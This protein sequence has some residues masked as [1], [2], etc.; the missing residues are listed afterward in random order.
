MQCLELFLWNWLELTRSIPIVNIS[1]QIYNNQYKIEPIDYFW[2]P[3]GATAYNLVIYFH[4]LN[5]HS[6]TQL[7]AALEQ[8][9]LYHSLMF[10]HSFRYRENKFF[11]SSVMVAR[12]FSSFLVIKWRASFSSLQ[13]D[14]LYSVGSIFPYQNSSKILIPHYPHRSFPGG[15]LPLLGFGYCSSPLPMPSGSG[16]HILCNAFCGL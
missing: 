2:K 13:V 3:M 10:M 15:Q 11:C 14:V 6:G 7:K 4:D 12:S 16:F 5:H 9:A 8:Q 1:K